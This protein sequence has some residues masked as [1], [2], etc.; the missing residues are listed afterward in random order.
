MK[1]SSSPV[2]ANSSKMLNFYINKSEKNKIS[3]D[4]L[5]ENPS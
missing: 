1:I 4:N 3:F 5:K 2:W